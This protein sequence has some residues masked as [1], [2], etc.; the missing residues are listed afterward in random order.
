MSFITIFSSVAFLTPKLSVDAKINFGSGLTISWNGKPLGSIKMPDVTLAA[1]EGAQLDITADFAV[2]DVDHLTDFTRTLLTEESFEW[3]IAGENLTIS[4]LGES[5]WFV[6]IFP[7]LLK[8]NIGIDVPGISLTTKKVSLLGMNGL[9]N[10]VVINSFDLPSNDPNGGIHLTLD[11]SVTNV[12]THFK[13]TQ[14]LN[15]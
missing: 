14:R 7:Q 15:A 12:S 4:A 2:S 5:L 10:G 8:Q 3:E 11:T 13:K 9:K 6:P 1:D